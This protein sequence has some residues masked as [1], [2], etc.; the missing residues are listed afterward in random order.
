M[1]QHMPLW[2]EQ[3]ERLVRFLLGDVTPDEQTEI[4]DRALVDPELLDEILAAGDDLIHAYLTGSLTEDETR[5]FETHFLSTPLRRQRFEL[6]RG[7]VGAARE[8]SAAKRVDPPKAWWPWAAAAAL[9]LLVGWLATGVERERT[10]DRVARERAPSPAAAPAL[11]S[12]N[13]A[14]P[15]P[16][17][18]VRLPT[19]TTGTVEMV[20]P[21][22][23]ES[24]RVEVPIENDRHPT[25][26]LEVRAADG[27]RVWSAKG[28]VASGP[29]GSLVAEIPTRVLVADAYELRVEGERLRG[30]ARHARVSLTYRLRVTRNGAP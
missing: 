29:A 25:Y 28:L 18:V 7:L 1:P 15:P 20:L 22:R 6:V 27:S 2:E 14:T 8:A 11:P 26:D 10:H 12:T 4:E 19:K 21:T 13:T 17:T 23:A 30:A 9:L 3:E 16:T 24:V 5:R